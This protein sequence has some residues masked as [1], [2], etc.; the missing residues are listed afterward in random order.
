M[1]A[2][3]AAALAVD[4]IPTPG[5][6]SEALDHVRGRTEP[7]RNVKCAKSGPSF[8]RCTYHQPTPKGYTRWAVLVSPED[9]GRWSVSEGPVRDRANS[10]RRNKR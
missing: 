7:V 2:W 6:L 10:V 3:P 4:D 9:D 1:V 8:V 5:E